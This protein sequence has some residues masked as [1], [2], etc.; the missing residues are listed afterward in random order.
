MW[1]LLGQND[2]KCNMEFDSDTLSKN[3]KLKT[4]EN[5]KFGQT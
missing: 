1:G 5:L 4:V 2:P 3:I